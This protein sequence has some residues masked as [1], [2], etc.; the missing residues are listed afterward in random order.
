[1]KAAILRK[2]RFELGEIPEPVP[3]AGQILVKPLVCGICGSDL[4]A[5]N[6]TEG[7][8]NSDA[9]PD[10]VDL[11][12]DLVLGHEFCC[13]VLESRA[14]SRFKAGARVVCF[15]FILDAVRP[16]ALGFSPKYP[17]G[18]CERML[19]TEDWALAVPDGLS[20]EL[21]ALTEPLAVGLHAVQRSG[22]QSG[23]AAMVV[24]CGPVGIAVIAALKAGGHGPVIASDFSSQR[25]GLAETVGADILVDPGRGS[26]HDQWTAIGIASR[27][28][29]MITAYATREKLRRT[30]IFEC[31]GA[32]GVIQSIIAGAPLGATVVCVGLCGGEDRFQPSQGVFKEIDLRFS[33]GYTHDEFAQTLRAI[34]DGGFAVGSLITGRAGLDGL[35]AAV[36]ELRNAASHAKIVVCP[37]RV[38]LCGGAGDQI[39]SPA[40]T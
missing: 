20:P 16:E 36:I 11:K 30:I 21:A 7:N 3:R 28:D 10:R 39:D 24:G 34:S 38:G 4:H 1:M 6:S 9:F 35:N 27:A 33:I 13:E 23:D 25:R 18:F 40:L 2:G 17:G 15:P 14:G 5:V 29:M 37:D 19:L 8:A 22:I 12:Q 31:V 32:P 26:P